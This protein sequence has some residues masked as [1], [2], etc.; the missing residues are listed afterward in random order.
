MEEWLML[1]W[2][3]KSECCRYV[4][5]FGVPLDALLRASRQERHL[6]AACFCSLGLANT[7]PAMRRNPFLSRVMLVLIDAMSDAPSYNVSHQHQD[8]YDAQHE[9]LYTHQGPIPCFD[10]FGPC[11]A[12]VAFS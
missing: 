12:I 7:L 6:V 8:H 4:V 3:T 10:W 11:E 1:C 9:S 5:S 2:D